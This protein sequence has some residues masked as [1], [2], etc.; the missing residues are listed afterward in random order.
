MSN[1]MVL[2]REVRTRKTSM[3]VSDLMQ[4]LLEYETTMIFQQSIALVPSQKKIRRCVGELFPTSG[5][6]CPREL[7]TRKMKQY[8]ILTACTWRWRRKPALQDH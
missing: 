5:R 4:V 1:S 2:P 7:I 6:V 3:D 8:S